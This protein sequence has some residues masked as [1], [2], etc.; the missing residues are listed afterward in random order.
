MIDMKKLLDCCHYYSGLGMD[1]ETILYEAYEAL[2]EA[3]GIME[4]INSGEERK[5]IDESAI[6]FMS[7][8]FPSKKA[9][10]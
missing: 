6:H 5:F 3:K 10:D 4:Y 2:E 9:E 1:S 7:K 8:Y